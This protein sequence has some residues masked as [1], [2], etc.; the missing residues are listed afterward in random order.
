MCE[1]GRSLR[2]KARI[3]TRQPLA[4]IKVGTTNADEREWL[5]AGEGVILEE[6]NIKSL[7]ILDDPTKLATPTVKPNMSRLGPRLGKEVKMLAT[8]LA[9]LQE[10]DVEKVKRLAFGE[11]AEVDG[12]LLDP[13][14]LSLIHI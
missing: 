1:L 11:S 4:G 13:Q 12:H 2:E 9:T 5:Q 10:I 8:T 14:D 6:L 7:E 3:R